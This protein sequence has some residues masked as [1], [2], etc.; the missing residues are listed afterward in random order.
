MFLNA[1]TEESFRK[2][3]TSYLTLKTNSDA[4]EED[5][6]AAIETAV[7]ADRTLAAELSVATIMSSWTQQAGYP[8]VTVKRDYTAANAAIVT[9]SQQRYFSDPQAA[10]TSG[11]WWIPYNLASS[12]AFNFDTTSATHWLS[13]KT[14]TVNVA[15]LKATDWFLLNKRQ[16][17]YYRVEYDQKN[18]ELLGAALLAKHN[19]IHLVSRAQLLDDA[20]DLVRSGRHSYEVPLE[21]AKYLAAETEYVPWASAWRALNLIDRLH[22]G[23]TKFDAYKAHVQKLISK[24]YTEVGLSAPIGTEEHHYRKQARRQ[25]IQMA[26]EYGHERCLAETAIKFAAYLNGTLAIHQ[27][28]RSAVLSNG[29]RNATDEQSQKLMQLLQSESDQDQRYRLI[30]ALAWSENP[31]N[32]KEFLQTTTG[33]EHRWNGQEE[34]YTAFSQVASRPTG[35]LVALEF[36]RTN[37]DD[38]RNQY[39]DRLTNSAFDRLA[40]RVNSPILKTKVGEL[41]GGHMGAQII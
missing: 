19:D 12:A 35:V 8:I 30:D 25:A 13:T 32:L 10:E 31:K 36:L 7:K 40:E 41:D 34:R 33:S 29:A 1:F 6:F 14:G 2:A 39:G 4:T 37:L 22:S 17:G 9:L 27:D 15:D 18:Y 20:F 28:E 26:C 21:L 38:V 11:T 3:L 24:L 5:L 16:T 23:S